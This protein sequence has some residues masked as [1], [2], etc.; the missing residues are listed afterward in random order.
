MTILHLAASKGY[1]DAAGALIEHGADVNA[2]VKLRGEMV[3]PPG[4]AVRAKQSKM[5]QFQKER[6]AR[7]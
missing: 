4:A 3:T 1:L 2:A 7:V 6:G 5:E